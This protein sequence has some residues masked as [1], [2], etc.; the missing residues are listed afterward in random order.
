VLPGITGLWQVSGR[1]KL[2]FDQR[3]KLDL[4]YIE[5]QCFWL[6]LQIM[7][8]TIGQVFAGEGAY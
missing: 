5:R 6:D 2:D 3:V 1:G 8:R 7:L 4:G